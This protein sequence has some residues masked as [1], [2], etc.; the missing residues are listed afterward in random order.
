[1]PA[2]R[3]LLVLTLLA[4]CGDDLVPETPIPDDAIPC[5]S[6]AL[7]PNGVRSADV[8]LEVRYPDSLDEAR[9][10]DVLTLLED[11]WAIEAGAMGFRAPIAVPGCGDDDDAVDVFLWPG[12]DEGYVEGIAAIEATPHDDWSTIMVLDPDGP[13]GGDALP[14][15]L[16]HELNHMMQAADDWDETIAVLE[17]TATF[18]ELAVVG[19]EDVR[20]TVR[21]DVQAHPDWA[22]DHDDGYETWAMY[23]SE[24]YLET[25]TGLDDDPALLGDLW[26]A[27]RNTGAADEPD[28]ADAVRAVMAPR[29]LDDTFVQYAIDRFAITPGPAI[30][31]TASPAD[32]SVALGTLDPYG[33]A[34]VTLTGTGTATLA[35]DGLGAELDVRIVGLPDGATITGPVT[36]PRTL[37]IVVVPVAPYDPQ[38]APLPAA[39]TLTW[40]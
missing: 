3:A 18:V 8:A 5:E 15:T 11:D 37:A 2:S 30:A 26:L 12:L 19:D 10:R 17:A 20:E 16:A 1:M 36:L 23:G 9:A 24:L 35:V 33:M 28:W 39:L 4:G 31:A 32:A 25:L 21:A 27:M 38:D 14:T 40:T 22:F 34:Y 13:Y 29:T 7:W 6:P